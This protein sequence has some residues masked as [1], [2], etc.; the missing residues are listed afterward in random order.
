MPT[1][2]VPLR[3][4]K[5]DAKYIQEYAAR[6]GMT[7]AAFLQRLVKKQL[8]TL[9]EEPMPEKM[10]E[11]ATEEKRRVPS[12]RRKSFW[13]GYKAHIKSRGNRASELAYA[14]IQLNLLDDIVHE[15]KA[16]QEEYPQAILACSELILSVLTLASDISYAFEEAKAVSS[17]ENTM[18]REEIRGILPQLT[19][20]ELY[21]L[22]RLLHDIQLAAKS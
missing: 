13:Q 10:I 2:A 17:L 8:A 12:P 14:R 20:Y 4:Q 3:F 1:V 6:L 22:D 18:F 21:E 7:K 16:Y 19:G 11:K 9:H 15:L 5:D